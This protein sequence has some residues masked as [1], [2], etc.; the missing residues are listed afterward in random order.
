VFR[1]LVSGVA[2]ALTIP[3]YGIAREAAPALRL[4]D[5][6]P[7]T[8]RGTGFHARERVTVVATVGAATRRKSL[9]ASATGSFVARFTLLRANACPGYSVRS[10]GNQG[11]RAALKPRPAQCPPPPPPLDP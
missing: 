2:L 9:T 6:V 8:V 7:L 5:T 4:T 11:S 10:W 1:V 3:A